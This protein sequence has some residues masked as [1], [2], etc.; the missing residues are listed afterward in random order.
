MG[1]LV[2][3]GVLINPEDQ[4]RFLELGVKDSKLLSPRRR[5][6]L[7]IE[8]RR[9]VVSSHIIRLTPKEIDKAVNNRKRLH[10]LNRLEARTMA[11]I[12]Q[13]LKPDIAI[14]DAANVLPDRY[15]Q[16]IM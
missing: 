16:H 5:E 9:I 8:I 3:A 10:K 11:E 15:I 7:A 2:V 13:T 4:R 14:V 1:P 12:I 6:T